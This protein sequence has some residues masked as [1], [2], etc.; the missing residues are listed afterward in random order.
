MD[1]LQHDGES[2]SKYAGGFTKDGKNTPA[3]NA[4]YYKKNREKILAQRRARM[5]AG[6]RAKQAK[7]GND[8]PSSR[9]EYKRKNRTASQQQIAGAMNANAHR[10]D[11]LNKNENR[12]KRKTSVS[13]EKPKQTVRPK[14]GGN[15]D[16]SQFQKPGHNVNMNTPHPTN[17]HLAGRKRTDNGQH[18]T[19]GKRGDGLIASQKE[20]TKKKPTVISK[21]AR[22]ARKLTDKD[23]T[24]EGDWEKKKTHEVNLKLRKKDHDFAKYTIINPEATPF[25][26]RNEREYLS[27]DKSLTGKATRGM[28][29]RSS[30]QKERDKKTAKD[31]VNGLLQKAGKAA[32]D[33]EQKAKKAVDDTKRTM[34]ETG[35]SIGRATDKAKKD[36]RDKARDAVSEAVFR[37]EM[38]KHEFKSKHGLY[39][40]NVTINDAHREAEKK[41]RRAISNPLLAKSSS[42]NVWGQK[43]SSRI[44][45]TSKPIVGYDKYNRKRVYRD[46]S[47]YRRDLANK[48]QQKDADGNNMH[49]NL[50]SANDRGYTPT[51]HRPKPNNSQNS[52]YVEVNTVGAN[53][54][55]TKR[56]YRDLSELSRDGLNPNLSNRSTGGSIHAYDKKTGKPVVFDTEAEF[57]SAYKSGKVHGFDNNGWE[58]L[59]KKYD[60][61]PDRS[62][63]STRSAM[64]N[65]DTTGGRRPQGRQRTDNGQHATV[66]KRGNGVNSDRIAKAQAAAAE[67]NISQRHHSGP[68]LEEARKRAE[69]IAAT[70]PGA[71]V[72]KVPGGTKNKKKSWYYKIEYPNSTS[73]PSGNIKY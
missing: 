14:P 50:L 30:E 15:V 27:E 70:V 71:K 54:R 31:F 57:A 6:A 65:G 72:V 49:T 64:P 40:G 21:E 26:P 42:E 67:A 35:K 69:A 46:E 16:Y 56:R 45:N 2:H 44:D 22:E 34:T 66:G 10:N 61:T 29:N 63:P 7:G 38:A 5:Q 47:E 17:S 62:T 20:E 3:Y 1:Y 59:K 73:G 25:G 60:D 43:P 41:A 53:G 13:G 11:Y 23:R 37:T 55:E 51:P 12:P 48:S 24:G 8:K 19:V 39:A 18:V 4:D 36:L 28:P 58:K 32:K 68:K 33:V 9:E 52:A